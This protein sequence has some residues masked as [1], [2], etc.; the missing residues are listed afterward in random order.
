MCVHW[1]T[2]IDLGVGPTEKLE[3]YFPPSSL[4]YKLLN[5]GQVMVH[6]QGHI[7]Y[8]TDADH[9]SKPLIGKIQTG[10][11]SG[12]YWSTLV[13]LGQAG[14]VKGKNLDAVPCIL[15]ECI[16]SSECCDVR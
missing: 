2:D 7:E 1:L 3:D 10:S 5:E 4:H 6:S 14:A 8:W 15:I 12:Q 9:E 11:S 13:I 16:P